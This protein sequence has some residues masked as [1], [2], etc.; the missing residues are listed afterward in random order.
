[1]KDILKLIR[2]PNLLMMVLTQYL[3]RYCIIEPVVVGYMGQ[4]LGLTNFDFFLIVFST[5]IIGA[6]GYIINDYYDVAIDAINKPGINILK[7]QKK[8]KLAINSYIVTSIIGIALGFY[9]GY[10]A[11]DYQLGYIN[12]ICAASLYYYSANF[13]G[14]FLIGNLMVAFLSAMV[15]LVVG[16]YDL[17]A[18][19]N[20]YEFASLI[21]LIG[22]YAAFAFLTT[23]VREII[24]DI[25]DI[26]GDKVDDC[27]TLP[28]KLGVPASKWIVIILS[29]LTMGAI[30]YFMKNRYF[31][32]DYALFYYLLILVQLPFAYLIFSVF[33]AESKQ[34]FHNASTLT[35][36][37]MLTGVLSLLAVYDSFSTV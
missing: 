1:M 3:V 25:E 14:K 32:E 24:K 26:E 33:K 23:L 37:I 18:L 34:D 5:F 36:I 17:I 9:I 12:S 15:P 16:L 20:T 4:P 22:G 8:Q 28:I 30:G 29:L 19:P 10:K 6:G 2:F 35:K 21:N 27:T 11:G 13:K 31:E 7:S